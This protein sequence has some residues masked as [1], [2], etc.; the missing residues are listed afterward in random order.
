[1]TSISGTVYA[2]S[3]EL[4][5]Y[6]VAV[7]VP[8]EELEPLTPGPTCECE[9]SGAPIASTLT[10]TKG[11][12]V[13]ENAPVGEDI[14]LV[15]QI[16]KWRRTLSVDTTQCVDTAL[17]DGTVKLPATQSEGDIP[18]IALSTGNADALECLIRKLGIDASEFTLPTGEGRV[19][20]FAGSGGASRY[21]DTM[22][23]GVEFPAAAD[24]WANLESLSAYDIVLLSC[25][26]GPHAA[27]KTEEAFQAMHDYANLGGRVFAS[28]HHG[29]WFQRGPEAFPEIA[30][31]AEQA[32]LGDIVAD[33][34]T[35]FP[36]GE[37][38]SQWLMNVGG[39]TT[40]GQVE[41]EGAQHTLMAENPEYAQRWIATAD[42]ES[43]Q[44]I[45]ANTPLGAPPAEQCGRVVLSDLHVSATSGV[46]DRSDIAIPFPD[47]CFTTG[48]TAQEQVLA[49]MLFDISACV[50]P[51]NEAPRPPDIR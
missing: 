23:E 9:I 36:K 1:V 5:L 42:P 45:S 24:M 28:H 2:P 11:Q 34:V 46:I 43:V 30:E 16:G 39:S 26:G 4:P 18:R 21:T 25:E 37:A 49:F 3:G 32:D 31:F 15:I 13:L 51:D 41:I 48:L 50:V 33:V 20:L 38:L 14:P 12:F 6:N 8:N 22:N 10:D 35:T 7:F 29:L 17:P 27:D 19:N 47:G 40:L 44:Y